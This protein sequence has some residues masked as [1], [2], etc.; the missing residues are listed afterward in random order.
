[1]KGELYLDTEEYEDYSSGYWE[2]DWIT[3]IMI[4]R[5][6]AIRSCL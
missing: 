3:S 1:M 4:I 5:E 6:S 2:A